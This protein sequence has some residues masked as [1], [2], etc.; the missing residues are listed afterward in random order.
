MAAEPTTQSGEIHPVS[1]LI[2]GAGVRL[3]TGRRVLVMG[4]LNITPD[5]FSDGGRFAAADAAIRRAEQLAAEG[6]DLID[7]GGESSRPGAEPVAADAELGRVLPVIEAVASRLPLPIS[8]D[9]VKAAVARRAL[10]AGARLI[11]DI[12]ALRADPGM[13]RVAVESSAPV[14]L[15]HMRGTPRDMQ[16]AP[17]YRDVVGEIAAFFEERLRFCDA[18]GVPRARVV[19]DPGIGFGK[20]LAHNLDI[21][22]GLPRFATLGR[23]LLVGPSRKSFIGQILDLPV[24]Q[25]LEGTAAAVAAAVLGGAAMVRVHDVAPMVRVVRVAEAIRAAQAPPR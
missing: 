14:I 24:D 5:S 25:R 13:V 6:A 10:A 17:R 7:I 20:T 12:S 16:H 23:P 8:I 15:M 22:R 21:L 4:I 11:N 18:S 2:E 9:T 1:T 3:E 19:L